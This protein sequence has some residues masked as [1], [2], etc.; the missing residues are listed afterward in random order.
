LLRSQQS[1]SPQSDPRKSAGRRAALREIRPPPPPSNF[2]GRVSYL[3]Q[4]IDPAR[5]AADR[6]HQV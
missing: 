2:A 1:H 3:G 4:Q 6:L 5:F